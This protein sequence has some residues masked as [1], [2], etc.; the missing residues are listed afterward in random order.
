[1]S[2]MEHMTHFIGGLRTQTRMLLNALYGGTLR[3]K[4]DEELKM[5]IKNMCL[6]EYRP[7]E[8][9]VKQKGF[10]VVYLNTTLVAQIEELSK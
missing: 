8:R 1:M 10:H 4:T 5:L 3:E 6:N 9:A 2:A 7:S